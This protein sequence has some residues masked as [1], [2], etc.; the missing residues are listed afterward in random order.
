[1]RGGGKKSKPAN[2][3]NTTKNNMQ[4][5]WQM[6]NSRLMP[7]CLLLGMLLS[8]IVTTAQEDT[9]F[10]DET[11]QTSYRVETYVV[12]N[13]PVGMVFLP[14]GS[15]LYNEK[16][17]GNVRL[18]SPDGVLQRNPVITLPTESTQ[19]RGMLGI[20]ID[21]N[22]AQNQWVYV[23]H[24]RVGSATDYPANE[25]VRFRLVDGLA[26]DVQV[27][28]SYPITTGELLH[29]GGNIHFDQNGYLFLSLGD[30]GDATN[31]QNL[32][33]PLG[34]INRFQVTDT[35]ITP[36]VGNP[37]GDDNPVWAYG[38]RNPFDFTFDPYTNNLFTSEVGP[39]CDD[40]INLVISGFNYGWR[41][42]YECVGMG[43]ISGLTLYSPPLL[44]FM[45]VEAPTGILVYDGK[46]FPEWQESLFFCNWN[47]GELRR[48]TLNASHTQIE[49]VFV[50]DL[51][52]N[53]C[54]IDLVQSPDGY[55]YFG[56]VGNST[57]AI[58]RI[59]PIE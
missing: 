26:Q 41:E 33:S 45:P 37:F 10:S 9:V 49:E 17:T 38:F 22:F 13:F 14:D 28:A 5:A 19:E 50:M 57:G 4:T 36:A 15:L 24:T 54:K 31:A 25:L 44:T 7:I 56:T 30:F 35:G 52:A 3:W 11:T 53:K 48:V 55:L 43:L 32:D 47:F 6:Q 2:I 51:G 20:A 46:A 8:V 21:P 29:N 12:A 27:L 40:E 34:K 39:N 58:M 18:V 42:D 1:M 16:I 59:V 23:V